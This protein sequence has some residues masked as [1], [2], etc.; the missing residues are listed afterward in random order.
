MITVDAHAQSALNDYFSQNGLLLCNESEELPFLDLVGG[1]WNAI[2]S[3]MES[4]DAF[5]S[6]FYK[7]RVTY[8]SPAL[9]YALKPYR[10]R[11]ERLSEESLRLL[12]FLRAIGQAN[13]PQMQAAC[14]LEKKAQVK[15]LDQLVSELFVT[16]LQRDET[17]HENWCTFTYG[18]AEQWEQKRPQVRDSHAAVESAQLLSRQLT[19]KQ[20]DRLLK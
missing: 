8:L 11:L 3:L 14:L 9:Y 5:Y 1:N 12:A 2:V 10:L 18:P 17:I 16:V 19:Q 6:R 20:I 15:A 13:A 4:G 7:N